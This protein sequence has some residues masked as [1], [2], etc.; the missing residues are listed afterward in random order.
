MPA[1]PNMQ[2]L[3]TAHGIALA[4]STDIYPALHR[5]GDAGLPLLLV[6]NALGR[7]VIAVHGAHVMAFQPA[8]QGEMLWLSPQC[9]LESGKP[10]RGGIPLCLPW[11]GPGIDG[12][13][14]HGFARTTDWAL[15]D[16]ATMNTGATR[17]AFELQGDATT[18]AL[19]PHAFKFRL[20][21]LV[22][23]ELTLGLTIENR[24]DVVA[25]LAFAFHT[26]FAVPHVAQT[27]VGGLDGSVVIDKLDNLSR[28]PQQGDVAI[29]SAMDR[30]YLDVAAAQTLKMPTHTVRIASDAHCAVVWNIGVNDKN[31]ADIGAGNHVGYLCVERGD[32]SDRA[33]NLAPGATH[34]RW[35]T[36]AVD[37]A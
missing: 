6:D 11:F 24:G 13:S 23:R 35:M 10:I 22:G 14:M 17:M 21:V 19:W 9:V 37:A 32:V 30:I 33:V 26:Y 4:N 31:V 18:H 29:P 16:A 36:L 27:L 34:R 1:Q 8:G 3:I 2:A 12:K 25:P 15:V 20:D 7:A 5:P 28:T